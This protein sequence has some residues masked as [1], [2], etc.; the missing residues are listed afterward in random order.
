VTRAAAVTRATD[1]LDHGRL[2]A[3]LARRVAIATESQEPERKPELRA[4]LDQEMAP[5]FAALGAETTI[6]EGA[7]LPGGPYLIARITEDAR[8]PT[9]F[10]YGHGDVIRGQAGRWADGRDPW[11]LELAGERVYGRGTADN[12]GQ[13][14]VNLAA[15]EAVKATRGRLGFNLVALIEMG[16][17]IGSPGLAAFA[18]T[19]RDALAADLLIASDGPR[20]AADRPTLFMGS[21]GALN[22]TLTVDLRPGGHHSGNWGGLLANPGVILAN[23]IASL[24][25]RDGH[26]LARAILPPPMSNAVRAA[27]ADCAPA[28]GPDE[29]AIDPDWGERGLTPAERVFGWNCLEVLAFETGNP[30]APVN[31]IPGRAFAVCQVRFVAD[32]DP[33]TLLPAIRAHLDAHGFGAVEVAAARDAVSRATRLDPDHPAVT[34]AA[35]SV[36]RTLGR[37]PARLPNLG[38]TLPND[39]FA[40]ILGLPTIWVPHSYAGCNQ[41]A[42]D[43]HALLPVLREGLAAMAGLFWDLGEAPPTL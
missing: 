5:A 25:D 34:W 39:V 6:H 35:A 19:H 28:P 32:T 26:V 9:L 8:L 4:Y 21:R 3:D 37:K 24:I 33:A 41:H 36:E 43:E 2:L 22:F 31:A 7:D 1:A 13:H 15:L 29:P 17:E 42:P 38:G 12:K 11:R 14:S 27:L 10:T 16:E 40:D 23:A 30:R 20:L 18:R